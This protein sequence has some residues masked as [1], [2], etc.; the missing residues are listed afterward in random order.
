MISKTITVENLAPHSDHPTASDPI[1]CNWLFLL[2]TL[3]FGFWITAPGTDHKKWRVGG[4]A[5]CFALS[6]AIKRA[7]AKGIDVTNPKF[8]S[9]VTF[10]ELDSILEGDDPNIK[11]PLLADRLECLHQVG[12]LLLEKYDG[13][14]ENC[15]KAAGGSAMR[16]LNIL[17][18]AFPCFRDEASYAGERVSFYRRSQILIVDLWS[19]FGGEGLGHF[20]DINALTVFAD[21]RVPQVLV[22]LDCLEYSN[23]LMDVLEQNTILQSGCAEEVE[24][25]GASIHVVEMLTEQ[26]LYELQKRYPEMSKAGDVNSILLGHYLWSNWRRLD[27]ELE[28]IPVHKTHSTNY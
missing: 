15:V 18:D 17:A 24:I 7:I 16:L 10:D 2:D 6:G 27:K 21:F 5:G 13:N 22:H 26:V 11:C 14:F 28:H 4:S 9:R 20:D 1:V 8:Y 23:K 3:D 19:V 25:R 12:T